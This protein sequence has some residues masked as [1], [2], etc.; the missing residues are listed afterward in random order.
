V[1]SAEEAPCRHNFKQSEL[2]GDSIAQES[3]SDEEQNAESG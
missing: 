1:K 2:P 3:F